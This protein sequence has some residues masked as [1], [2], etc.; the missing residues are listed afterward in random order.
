MKKF[1]VVLN[2]GSDFESF[3]S[4]LESMGYDIRVKFTHQG[5]F[6]INST[7]AEMNQ[8]KM[9]EDVMSISTNSLEPY[10]S[11]KASMFEGFVEENVG[12]SHGVMATA[13]KVKDGESIS[14]KYSN[15]SALVD[16]LIDGLEDD[17]KKET[18]IKN[19]LAY[20][21]KA[22]KDKNLFTKAK[23]IFKDKTKKEKE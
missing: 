17:E 16:D 6:Y 4:Q 23:E 2:M 7:E 3:S 18:R 20:G 21:E 14:D 11:G 1:S 22:G 5:I 10:F 8:L 15:S 19:M 13:L 12:I 9:H